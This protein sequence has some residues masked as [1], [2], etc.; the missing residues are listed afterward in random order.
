M[1]FAAVHQDQEAVFVEAADVAAADEAAP[2]GVEPFGLARL[3]RLVV[4]AGHHAGRTTDDL[5]DHARLT[6]QLAAVFVEQT[7]VVA[8]AGWPTVCS[9]CGKLPAIQD[10]AA[11]ASV[12]P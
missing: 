3:R 7:D 8:L 4:I 1:S 2:F 5:A 9:L 12:M 10:A 6:R 11:A